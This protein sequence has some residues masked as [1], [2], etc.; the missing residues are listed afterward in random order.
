[1]STPVRRSR[2]KEWLLRLALVFISSL[3][4]LGIA[5]VMVR[6][7]HPISDGRANVTLEGKPIAGFVEPGTVYRQIANEYNAI[8]T[9]TPKGHRVPAVDGSPDVIFLGD[10]FTFGYGL[11]DDQTFASIYCH[12]RH[13]TCANLG[14]PDS[15]TLRQVERLE[16]FLSDYQW[17]PKEVKLFFFGMSTSFSAGND[18]ADNYDREIADRRPAGSARVHVERPNQ[19]LVERAIGMQSFLFSH[20]TLLRLAKFYWGPMI[21]SLVVAPPGDRM[22]TA[23]AATQRSLARFDALSRQQGFDYTIYLIV[24]VQ[25]LIRG[26]YAETLATLNQV[27]PK[28]AVATADVFLS[29]PK[30]FF[31]AFDGHLNPAGSRRLDVRD[32][33]PIREVL[34]SHRA[35]AGGCDHPG[36]G[37]RVG[38]SL[39][40]ARPTPRGVS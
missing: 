24:P 40:S 19:G 31:F 5:E 17:R 7:F 39:L 20:S 33:A 35:Q 38:D 26:S 28:P 36:D 8:T 30:T 14:I 2:V 25:D 22:E 29:A 34:V 3:F 4:A 27:S 21:K 12:D 10:S 23:L 16:K 37:G 1:M 6:V 15:G 32:Q 11:T 13:V 18:F 9:I